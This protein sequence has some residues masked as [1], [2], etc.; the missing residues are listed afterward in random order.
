MAQRG[1]GPPANEWKLTSSDQNR[2]K[3]LAAIRAVD[4]VKNHSAIGLGTGTTARCF[5]E[6]LAQRLKD[7]ALRS[8]V[9][10]P[11]SKQTAELA[12]RLHIPLSSLDQHPILDL[13]I[14]GADEIDPHLDL[15][16]G[17]GGA[18][19]REKIVAAAARQFLIIAD[20]SKQVKS[21]GE[22]CAVPIEVIPFGLALVMQRLRAFPGDAKLRQTSEGQ[23]FHTDDGNWIV[24]Y[25]CRPLSDPRKLDMMLN[26]IPGI[27]EHGLFLNMA[28][29]AIVGN[30][31]RATVLDR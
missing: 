1:T 6:E 24:D 12:S 10:I 22:T 9:G 21:L 23:P 15:I 26:S 25:A 7:G 30:S 28:Q 4:E 2:S 27:V 13:A 3:R 31:C 19:L 17:H 5:L 14:D 8:V 18:L 29:R 11:T 16:K 20:H